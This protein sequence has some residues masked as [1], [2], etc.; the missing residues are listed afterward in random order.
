M[1]ASGTEEAVDDGRVYPY[2]PPIVCY[3]VDALPK[4]DK[5]FYKRLASSTSEHELVQELVIPPR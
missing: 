5:A 4:I 2:H 1:A 3:N